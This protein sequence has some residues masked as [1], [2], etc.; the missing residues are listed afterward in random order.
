MIR[1][2]AASPTIKD[3]QP[4]NAAEF[5]YATNSQ[6]C[7]IADASA[8]LGSISVVGDG[9]PVSREKPSIPVY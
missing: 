4:S 6:P 5:D 9:A 1:E 3:E 2:L 8:S 7:R